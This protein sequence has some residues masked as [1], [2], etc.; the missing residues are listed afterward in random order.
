MGRGKSA[1]T[2]A[3]VEAARRI[4]EEIQPA[5]VRA[6]CYRLFIEKLIPDMGKN[7]TGSVS[8]QLVWAREQGV[9]PWGWI[10]DETREA[11]RVS[12]WANPEQIIRAAVN[13]YRKDYW[14]MQPRRVEVWSEKG[15][16]RGT[17]APVLNEHGVTFRVMHGYGS[18]TSLYGIAQETLDNT[19]PLTI[20]Y[21]GDWDCSGLHMS[22]VDL[23]ARLG[24]YGGEATIERIALEARD[25]H[26]RTELPWFPASDKKNDTRYDW[27]T[28]RYGHRCWEVDALSP[29][30]LR[31]RLEQ[32][33]DALL[34]IEAWNHAIEI[35]QAETQSMQDFMGRF[36]SILSPAA[37]YSG[38]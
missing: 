7:S 4:L 15:T 29:V 3:L 19:K 20:L 36:K 2:L 21:I 8:K 18:A 32:R 27:F 38:A 17:V 25:V 13:G 5:S 12:T 1:K 9:I 22:E 33:I 24:R 14:A 31:K 30:I 28:G 11:E 37:K 34:D 26:A 16:I 35:E 10:V 6:V 23:P